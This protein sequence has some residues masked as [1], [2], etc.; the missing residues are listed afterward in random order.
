MNPLALTW[1]SI[2]SVYDELYRIIG[3]NFIWIIASV[4]I[5]LVVMFVLT[6]ILPGSELFAY[7]LAGV[8]GLIFLIG[9]NPAACGLHYFARHMVRDEILHFSFF[10][11]GLRMFW[12]RATY[13][14]LI[15]L[16]VGVV[17]IVNINFYLERGEESVIFTGVGVFIFWVLVIWLFMQPYMLPLLI[18]QQDKRILL[19]LRNSALLALDNVLLSLFALILFS[20]LGLLAVAVVLIIG[21]FGGGLIIM[22]SERMTLGLLPKYKREAGDEAAA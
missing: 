2:K 22:I 3:M 20:A 12:S 18:E 11:D 6:L 5:Y 1:A 4:A 8:V 21:T 13:L 10:W 14:F 15:S 19:V 7:F 16:G 17:L 9:P